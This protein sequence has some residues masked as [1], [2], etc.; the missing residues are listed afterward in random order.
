MRTLFLAG[1]WKMNK[2]VQEATTFVNEVT[3]FCTSHPVDKISILIAPTFLSLAPCIKAASG[4]KLLIGAQNVH[5]K[6]S[7]A[8]T[9]EVSP[10]LLQDIG[11]HYAIVGHSERRQYFGETNETVG[12]R[13][14]ASLNHNIIPI[15]CCGERLEDRDAG[16]TE[17]IVGQQLDAVFKLIDTDLF[18]K[19][20]VAYEPVWAI[21]TGAT[22]SPEDAQAVHQFIRNKIQNYYASDVADKIQ[23][24]YGGSV[25][26]ENILELT[27]MPDIDGALIGGA[28]LDA[29]S[30]IEMIRIVT[31]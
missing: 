30:F 16:H 7:G 14:L 3:Q 22:A 6:N 4:S 27:A 25:K 18:S 24:L 31:S 20:I 23:L 13:A 28:S 11:C 5:W 21:G 9:A 26:P 29:G 10:A 12:K 1:N 2:T 19:C 17:Q 8:F 15:I